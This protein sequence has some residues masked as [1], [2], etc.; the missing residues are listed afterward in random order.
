MRN[1]ALRIVSGLGGVIAILAI[2][3]SV[4]FAQDYVPTAQDY[5]N[6]LWVFIAGVLRSKDL[7]TMVDDAATVSDFDVNVVLADPVAG[8]ELQHLPTDAPAVPPYAGLAG[9]ARRTS[10]IFCPSACSGFSCVVVPRHVH[11]SLASEQ[12]FVL[13]G[14]V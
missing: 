10:G 12:P 1:R 3:P 2:T 11:P 8:I 9:E 13:E 14:L 4:G 7:D 6:N 5:L